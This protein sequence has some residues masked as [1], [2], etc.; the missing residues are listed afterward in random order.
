MAT[1]R[2]HNDND[3][4]HEHIPDGLGV[5][6]PGFHPGGPGSIPGLGVLFRYILLPQ[7]FTCCTLNVPSWN[8]HV[9]FFDGKRRY[10]K[11]LEYSVHMK[12]NEILKWQKI[13]RDNPVMSNVMSSAKF[14][15]RKCM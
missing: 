10:S 13:P 3:S 4:E 1:G 5:R 15:L 11:F 14:I 7:T 6:I 8:F 9:I 12:Y 2:I